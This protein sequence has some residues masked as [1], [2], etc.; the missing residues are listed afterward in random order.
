MKPG[1]VL[2]ET[3]FLEQHVSAYLQYTHRE[4]FSIAFSKVMLNFRLKN[5]F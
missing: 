1:L 4:K 2:L 5:C 3:D